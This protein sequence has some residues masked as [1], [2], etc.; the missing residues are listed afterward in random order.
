MIRDSPTYVSSQPYFLKVGL[1]HFSRLAVKLI[2]L[3]KQFLNRVCHEL[4]E[5][6]QYHRYEFC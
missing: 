4:L 5:P 3:P 1:A 6:T 2:F